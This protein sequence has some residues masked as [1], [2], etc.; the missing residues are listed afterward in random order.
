MNATDRQPCDELESNRT[1]IIRSERSEK[2]CVEGIPESVRLALVR[3]APSK[4]PILIGG[5]T[6]TGKEVVARFIHD[7]SGLPGPF[8]GVNCGAISEQLADSELFGHEAGSFTG[9]TSRQK[10]WFEAANNGTLFLDEVGDLASPLQVKL[11]RVL[12]E[13]E[14]F[15]VG[16]RSPITV[17][18]RIIAATNVDLD[19]AVVAGVFRQ[20]LFYRLNAGQVYLPPLRTRPGDI[21]LLANHILRS[22]TLATGRQY[23]TLT[24]AALSKLCAYSWPGNIRE[25]AN[26]LHRGLIESNDGVIHPEH[27]HIHQG[28]GDTPQRS[29]A[30]ATHSPPQASGTPSGVEPLD[31][32]RAEL[33][34]LLVASP[35]NLF[36]SVCHG[37]ALW[38]QCG[39]GIR[40]PLEGRHI[41][42]SPRAA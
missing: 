11:L 26:V 6:G 28:L 17:N 4:L 25:L 32:I 16:S 8:V 18:L 29:S 40:A 31:V 10:G 37:A 19:D 5:E 7:A 42:A 14:L 9:A 35:T 2:I 39:V 15:R 27:L 13:G 20:D 33:E 30:A 34:R 23:A 1:T 38:S 3:L 12:Q 24:V 36:N 21:P 22:A 41:G